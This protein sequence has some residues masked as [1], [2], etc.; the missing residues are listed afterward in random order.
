MGMPLAPLNV[1]CKRRSSITKLKNYLWLEIFGAQEFYE[2][3]EVRAGEAACIRS[4]HFKHA[5]E[6]YA[7]VCAL[8]LLFRW[9]R[10][11]TRW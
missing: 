11:R 6:S 4:S 2:K 10:R 8:P 5:H 7:R 1:E 3:E 9:R